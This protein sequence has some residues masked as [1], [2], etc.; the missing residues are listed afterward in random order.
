MRR[1]NRASTL[2][3]IW[4]SRM[5]CGSGLNSEVWLQ[6]VISVFNYSRDTYLGKEVNTL[7]GSSDLYKNIAFLIRSLIIF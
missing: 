6:R 7:S 3:P 5:L 4:G 1:F 2:G